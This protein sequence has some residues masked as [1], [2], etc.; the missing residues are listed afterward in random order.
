MTGHDLP[1]PADFDHVV[2]ERLLAGDYSLARVA[3]NAERVAV[4]T[5]TRARGESL[6]SL[7]KATGWNLTREQDEHRARTTQTDHTETR[8]SA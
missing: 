2:V 7:R 3:T 1:A 6:N 4:I 8:R 5:T